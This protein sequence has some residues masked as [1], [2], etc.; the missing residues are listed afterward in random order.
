MWP[1]HTT[2]IESPGNYDCIAR[3]LMD[4]IAIIG[5]SGAGKTTLAKKI[6]S[7][8]KVKVYHLDRF[9][10]Q[11]DWIRES[12]ERRIDTLKGFV[13]KRQWIIEG[14]YLNSSELHLNEADIIIFL[15]MPPF[16]CFW[17]I[18]M[19]HLNYRGLRRCDIPKGSTNRLTFLGMLQVL[20]FRL[21][22]HG[23]LEDKL[24]KFPQEKIIRLHSPKEVES[25]L[26]RL[27]IYTEEK[28]LF[29][30]TPV[31]KE[32]LAPARR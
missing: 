32:D 8:L 28:R 31:K 7:R 12:G 1:S 22:A 19:R 26:A 25:F 29:S 24:Y 9:F 20:A 13:Q 5:S 21:R 14:T 16:L 4:K 23:K 6:S 3:E 17:R 27:E 18:I 30:P 11:P 15:D 10:W 2:K